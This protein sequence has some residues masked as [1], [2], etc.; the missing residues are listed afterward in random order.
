MAGVY[1]DVTERKRLEEVR[2]NSQKMEAL[3]TLAGGIAHD[4]N[5]ILLAI[6]GNAKLA[7]ED[8][9]IENIDPSVLRHGLL[10]I[11]KASLRATE[12][13]RRILTFSRQQ[14]VRREVVQLKPLIEEALRLLR[15]S[16]GQ[17]KFARR[18][19]RRSSNG[20]C[21][22]NSA[23]GDEL[24]DQCRACHRITRRRRRNCIVRS[25]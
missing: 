5:N 4:F 15:P 6:S 22:S 24:S 23:S 25:Q 18:M 2:L 17:C 1:V 20:R 3:G 16:Y 13:V 8:L 14:D 19:R 21:H 11:E 10:E 9:R 7:L 12:L